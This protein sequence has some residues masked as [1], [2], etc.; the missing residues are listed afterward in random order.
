[1]G[2]LGPQFVM[3][4]QSVPSC[5]VTIFHTLTDL[6]KLDLRGGERMR[7]FFAFFFAF[8]STQ[9]TEAQIPFSQRESLFH[10]NGEKSSFGIFFFFLVIC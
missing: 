7:F 3:L 2:I 9:R 5:N 10:K 4:L 1:M 8:F 6:R